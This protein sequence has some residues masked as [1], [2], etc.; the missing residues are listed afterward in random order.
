MRI[1]LVPGRAAALVV[2]SALIPGG[3]IM[4]GPTTVA[5]QRAPRSYESPERFS[6]ELLRIGTYRPAF[7]NSVDSSGNNPFGLLFDGDRGPLVATELDVYIYRIPYVGP[8]GVGVGAGWARY[9]ASTCTD[10]TCSQRTNEGARFDLFPVSPLA[11]LRVDVLAR[12]LGIPVVFVGKIGAD[13]VF[14]RYRQGATN[15]FEGFSAG[16]RWAAQLALE[17][18]FLD[19]G[20]ARALDEDWGIN[21]SFVFFELYGSSANSDLS[22]GDSL[23]WATGLGFN[24]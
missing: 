18:D 8:I 23:A 6:W 19:R 17:L 24:F 4:T 22:V 1:G 15:N 13:L 21:H 5:A 14:Y 12:E 7:D 20:S 9:K 11:V 16:L 10:A 2:L 3:L